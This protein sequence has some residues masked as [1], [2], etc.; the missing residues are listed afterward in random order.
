MPDNQHIGVL[1]NRNDDLDRSFVKD[2]WLIERESGEAQCLT[3]GS[4]EILSFAWSPDGRQAMLVAEKDLRIAGGCTSHLYLLARGGGELRDMSAAIDNHTRVAAFC[5]FGAAGTYRPQWSADGS[6]VYFLVTEQGCINVYRLDI[7][8]GEATRLTS[9]E[10]LIAYLALLPGERALLLAQGQPADLWD[11]YHIPLAAGGIG[12]PAKLTQLN[13]AQL[14]LSGPQRI[15]YKGA[16]GDE[17]EGWVML[18]VGAKPGV[19]Y[20]LAVRI[21]G[22]PQSAYGVGMNPYHQLLAA[23]GFAV[24]YC[25]P[26]GSTGHGQDFMREV[27]GDWGGWDYQDIM[28]GVDEC[29]ARGI[30]DPQRLG[31]VKK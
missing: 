11:I 25:N 12:T 2:L 3:D 8:T 6:R 30:A 17:I 13:D 27:E 29:I 20:P 9:G 1:C 31:V 23:H 26:H 19:R 14:A 22:G 4:L 21:H 15:A 18:P 5:G 10:H 28:R 16:N 7:A 24:F